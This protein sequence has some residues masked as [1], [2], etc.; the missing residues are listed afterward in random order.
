MARGRKFTSQQASLL[1]QAASCGEQVL[2][3]GQGLVPVVWLGEMLKQ[4]TPP[5]PSPLS[6]LGLLGSTNCVV[7]GYLN[8][9]VSEFTK[10]T[11]PEVAFHKTSH[12]WEVLRL[13]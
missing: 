5:F 13:V 1:L 11:F 10:H 12:P 2:C 8:E 7:F 3:C 9:Y 6:P 4:L